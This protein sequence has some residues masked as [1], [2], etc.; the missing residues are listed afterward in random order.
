MGN[1]LN[2]YVTEMQAIIPLAIGAFLL[3]AVFSVLYNHW[4]AALGEKKEGYLAI[5][6]AIGNLITLAVVAVFSWKAALIVLVALTASGTAM[7]LG[8]VYRAINHREH[9][10]TEAKKAPRR[11]PL[12]Y[13]AGRLIADAI[14][15]LLAAEHKLGQVM[16]D[17]KYELIPIIA[18]NVS[19]SL[20]HLIEAKSSEGE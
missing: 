3:L 9:V 16:T 5:L 11:K 17:K 8:D 18:L 6:V 4:M 14:D 2:E 13:V 1:F 20:R 19:K 15:E 12:P 10:A 7:I